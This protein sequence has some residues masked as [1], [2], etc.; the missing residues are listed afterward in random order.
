MP[1][2]RHDSHDSSLQNVNIASRFAGKVWMVRVDPVNSPKAFARCLSRPLP[3][4][5]LRTPISRVPSRFG[6]DVEMV[7]TG[8]V[9]RPNDLLPQ[10][11]PVRRRIGVHQQVDE[12]HIRCKK[13]V[14]L[15][16]DRAASHPR[17]VQLDR[18]HFIR[19]ASGLTL[20]RRAKADP[21]RECIAASTCSP[22]FVDR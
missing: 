11:L 22:P 15:W 21:C 16:T 7:C 18:S 3:G 4:A 13:R 14:A 6:L 2:T 20:A 17:R 9:R 19:T 1:I 10:E 12:R 8:P 5:P